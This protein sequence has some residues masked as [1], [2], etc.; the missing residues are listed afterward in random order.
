MFCAMKY[1]TFSLAHDATER[2]GA[3][4]SDR[5]LDVQALAAGKWRGPFPGSLLELIQMGPEAWRHMA[6]LL[7]G[8]G[9]AKPPAG[10]SYPLTDI[11]WHAPIPRPRKNV[12]CLGLNYLSHMKEAAAARGREAKIPEVPVFFSKASTTVNGPFDPIPWD[13]SVTGQVDYEAELGVIIGANG[14]SIS[15]AKSLDHVFG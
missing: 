13:R 7:D 4:D 5:V 15:R 10:S 1:V 2:P 9:S 6:G 14:K 8:A 3:I 11:R 12:F